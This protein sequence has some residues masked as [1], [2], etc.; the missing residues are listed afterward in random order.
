MRKIFKGLALTVVTLSLGMSTS[1][2]ADV[3]VTD[4][5]KAFEDLNGNGGTIQVSEFSPYEGVK[6]IRLIE[7]VDT[8]S[9]SSDNFI[10]DVMRK[11]NEIGTEDGFD[12]NY[13]Y[14][15]VYIDGDPQVAS[16]SIYDFSNDRVDITFWGDDGSMTVLRISDGTVIK[17]TGT[18]TDVV[19]SN[20]QSTDDSNLPSASEPTLGEQNAYKQAL[21]YLDFTSFSYSG[22]IE[23]LEYEGFSTE[24]AIYGA[25]N[26]GADWNEQAAK[27][28]Q[29]YLDFTSLSRV[30]LIEQLEYEGFT[31]EQAE[32]GASAVGF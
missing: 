3:T 13:I 7:T 17:E 19:T 4:V 26:C 21:S 25:N 11:I 29:S 31:K 1:V 18:L 14:C 10:G 20:S 9:D 5:E 30:G 8:N 16:S 32:Y 22:L 24:E 28:A 27:K 23:Q 6:N 2:Y 15:D 12:Y